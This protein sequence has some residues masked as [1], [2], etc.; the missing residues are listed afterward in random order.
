MSKRKK[1]KFLMVITLI[2]CLLLSGCSLFRRPALPEE[3]NQ[4]NQPQQPN[5]PRQP[6]INR[7]ASLAQELANDITV[8]AEEI[9]G[10]DNASAIVLGNLALI[11]LE[12]RDG[13]NDEQV[14]EQVSSDIER[15]FEEIDNAVVTAD[16][17]IADQIASVAERIAQGK[18]TQ[19]VLDEV[20]EIWE[21]M[22]PQ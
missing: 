14:K 1:V 16:P 10:V 17:E 9:S 21:K 2:G 20:F 4:L 15:K 12:L 5:D 3:G 22:R 11:G 13:L 19:E 8:R 7:G 18:P 6:P